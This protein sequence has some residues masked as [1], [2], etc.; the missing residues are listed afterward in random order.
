MTSS[1]CWDGLYPLELK[2]KE[3]LPLLN[4]FVR[5]L[6]S[7][8]KTNP[9]NTCE[10]MGATPVLYIYG[11]DGK[12]LAIPAHR[13]SSSA[14]KQVRSQPGLHEVMPQKRKLHD[15]VCES[16]RRLQIHIRESRTILKNVYAR[17]M[18]S[19]TI[20]IFFV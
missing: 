5:G 14:T 19:D 12:M 18:W 4:C 13:R 7:P 8:E 17:A 1:S 16:P 20:L 9:P 11:H 3:A 6:S 2:Q 10:A 15:L